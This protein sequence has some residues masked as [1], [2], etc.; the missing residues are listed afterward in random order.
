M[1][2]VLNDINYLKSSI[3]IIQ[4]LVI[5]AR[6]NFNK[7][8]I[9]LL[10]MD[11]AG[12]CFIYFKLLKS[13]FVNYDLDKDLD[14]CLKVID[15]KQV[16]KKSSE[17]DVLVIEYEE[18]RLILTLKGKSRKEFKIN[19]I[20]L[21]QKDYTEP[22]L[23]FD[24]VVKTKSSIIKDAINTC[25]IGSEGESVTITANPKSLSFHIEGNNNEATD[26]IKVSDDTKITTDIEIISK[27]SIEYLNKV[28]EGSKL[29]ENIKI[30]LANNYPVKFDFMI[31]DKV[32]LWLLVAPRID[33]ND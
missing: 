3:E 4:G 13:A 24:C 29:S 18:P 2:L 10:S 23:K 30:E 8:G 15:L 16:L 14:I 7:E 19:T 25:D 27:F 11:P 26:T 21:E 32:Q 1:K 9:S 22:T 5:E 17:G 12:V 20:D 6:F 33:K 28:I 31:P